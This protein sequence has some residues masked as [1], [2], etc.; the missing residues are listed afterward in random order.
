MM[1][2]MI[3]S[4]ARCQTMIQTKLS[5]FVK[6][7]YIVLPYLP[8]LSAMIRPPCL[9]QIKSTF[10]LRRSL[11]VDELRA[12]YVKSSLNTLSLSAQD[13]IFRHPLFDT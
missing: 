2:L 3:Y 1:D 7:K 6:Y 12:S 10:D 5:P 8:F 9:F 4:Q 11:L 13:L